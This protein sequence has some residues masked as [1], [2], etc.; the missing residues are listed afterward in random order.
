MNTRIKE[1]RSAVKLTQQEFAKRIGTTQNV[2]ANYESGRRNPSSSVINN[3]CKTFGVREAW[4]RHGEGDMLEESETISLDE[5]M[6][7]CGVAVSERKMVS[8]LVQTYFSLKPETRQ[9]ILD[10]FYAGSE[11]EEASP[12]KFQEGLKVAGIPFSGTDA[13]AWSSG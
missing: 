10:H 6:D 9:D 13:A 3:I 12:R 1:L 2:L 4:L 8:I 7:R 5:L 11:P